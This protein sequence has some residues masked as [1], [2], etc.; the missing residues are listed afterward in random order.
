MSPRL[1]ETA[2]CCFDW[3]TILVASYYCLKWA[4][5][6][7]MPLSTQKSIHLVLN[8]FSWTYF[9]LN[10]SWTSGERKG[11]NTLCQMVF[12]QYIQR[13]NSQYSN[14]CVF[15]YFS[16]VFFFF[17]FILFLFMH[18]CTHVCMWKVCYIKDGD[19]FRKN[20]VAKVG[21]IYS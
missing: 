1:N 17:F 14:L 12:K 16:S 5:F 2:Y 9:N 10:L 20:Q 8:L 13:N 15:C 7:Y 11:Y 19:D 18:V 6:E 3:I 21:F 4:V